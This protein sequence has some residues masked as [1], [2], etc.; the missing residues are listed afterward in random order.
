MT[1]PPAPPFAPPP[2]ESDQLSWVKWRTGLI[3]QYGNLTILSIED[4]SAGLFP[5]IDDHIHIAG[6][7]R[8]DRRDTRSRGGGAKEGKGIMVFSEEQWQEHNSASRVF[9]IDIQAPD[10]YPILKYPE[11]RMRYKKIN[12][13]GRGQSRRGQGSTSEEPES[14]GSSV[15]IRVHVPASTGKEGSCESHVTNRMVSID[16]IDFEFEKLRN[17]L[18]I[19]RSNNTLAAKGGGVGS[20]LQAERTDMVNSGRVSPSLRG[21]SHGGGGI[22]PVRSWD[23]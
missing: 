14:S 13:S 4:L 11:V 12:A 16:Q 10:I 9:G 8:R 22:P 7:G 15:D 2:A 21:R 18:D 23:R 1:G 5:G 20:E 17:R 3:L 6:T 19:C